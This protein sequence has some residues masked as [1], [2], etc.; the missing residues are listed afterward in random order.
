LYTFGNIFLQPRQP[1]FYTP[2]VVTDDLP[3]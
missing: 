1:A 2:L 3:E